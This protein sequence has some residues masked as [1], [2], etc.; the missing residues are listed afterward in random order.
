MKTKIEKKNTSILA[1]RE[2]REVKGKNII[3]SKPSLVDE[4]EPSH[5]IA[6]LRCFK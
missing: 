6:L 1:W 4:Y 5:W 2:K 3:F